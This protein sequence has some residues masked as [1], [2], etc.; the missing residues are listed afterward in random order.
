MVYI[1]FDTPCRIRIRLAITVDILR[2][3]LEFCLQT[4]VNSEIFFTVDLNVEK[5]RINLCLPFLLALANFGRSA[6]ALRTALSKI[7]V[8]EDNHNNKAKSTRSINT[9]AVTPTVAMGISSS[10]PLL[11]NGSF[12]EAEVVFWPGHPP[13]HRSSLRLSYVFFVFF[14]LGLSTTFS[15]FS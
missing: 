3:S 1:F 10:P 12:K 4:F 5:F 7:D 9:S 8:H 15:G 11:I 14:F 6:I 13:R 2:R